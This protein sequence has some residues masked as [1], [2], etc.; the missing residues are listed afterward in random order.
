MAI[1]L[2]ELPVLAEM[3]EESNE[4]AGLR[5]I[6]SFGSLNGCVQWCVGRIGQV[7]FVVP[8]RQQPYPWVP[9]DCQA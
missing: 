6:Q 3:V 1:T 8:E 4:G 5:R 2:Q 9:G 7:E